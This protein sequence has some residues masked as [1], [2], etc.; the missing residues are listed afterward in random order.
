[1]FRY[2]ASPSFTISAAGAALLHV[3][4][5]AQVWAPVA[6]PHHPPQKQLQPLTVRIINSQPDQQ[7]QTSTPLNIAPKFNTHHHIEQ[8]PQEKDKKPIV[9][10]APPS[11]TEQT[12]RPTESY[13]WPGRSLDQ[14]PT[15]ETA[16]VIPYPKGFV[17]ITR[18][19][20]I[21][22]LFINESGQVDRVEVV[23]SDA[24]LEFTDMARRTFL[25][26]RFTPGVKDMVQVRSKL[27]IE[28]GFQDGPR[29]D[30]S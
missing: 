3:A 19:H 16:V 9:A 17:S 30:D 12:P 26:T 1:M 20:A 4:G 29:S 5:V 22:Q 28:I 23:E 21:L 14:K 7:H 27:K 25:N 2:V 18:G 10:I 11:T 6:L 24:P 13:Y 8:P 15:P